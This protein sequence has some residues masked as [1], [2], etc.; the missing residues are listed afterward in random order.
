MT[1]SA[2]ARVAGFTFLAYIAVAF[3]S[4][5]L[6]T[7]ATNAKGTEAQLAL[8]AAHASDIR[9]AIVLGLLSCF[10]AIVL[11]VLLY[12]FTRDEDHELATLVLVSRVG[13]GILGAVG[14]PVLLALLAIATNAPSTAGMDAAARQTIAGFLLM[15]AQSVM[16][17]APF[18]AIGSLAFSVLLVRGRMVPRALAWLGVFASAVLVVGV[19]LNIAR[20]ISGPTAFYLWMPA[21]AFEV[22][23]GF[24]LLIKGVPEIPSA[25]KPT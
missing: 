17:G 3:P 6:I 12:G 15:P 10:A 9:I 25:M 18:F 16:L 2:A 5:V 13:E 20:F 22:P 1:R 24:W 23:L 19:P 4:S 14:I 11:A 7:R 8:V 21:L